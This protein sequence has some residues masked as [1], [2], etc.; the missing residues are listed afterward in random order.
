MMTEDDLPCLLRGISHEQYHAD[1]FLATPTLSRSVAHTL[2]SKSP[3]HAYACHPRLGGRSTESES[4]AFT[5]GGLLHSLILGSGGE[6]V[7]LEY[8]S[9]RT[10]A[11]QQERDDALARGATP[12]LR[13]AYEA[14][15]ATAKAVRRQIDTL[16]PDLEAYEQEVTVLWIEDGVACRARFDLVKVEAGL[17]A[18]TK[19]QRDSNPANFARSMVAYGYDMQSVAYSSALEACHPELAGRVRF[20]FLLCEKTPPYACALA[21]AAGTMK[22]LGERRWRRGLRLWRQCLES[23]K[24]PGYGSEVHRIEAKPWQ[25]EEA[26]IDEIRGT[27]PDWIKED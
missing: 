22:E 7:V 19:F 23:G 11:A 18:D 10:K 20:Q 14:N 16:V 9:Y 21:E 27:E 2:V 3:V 17:I 25:L 6:V 12:M 26:M 15:L 13:E 24:W 5:D 8:D 1:D 4:A